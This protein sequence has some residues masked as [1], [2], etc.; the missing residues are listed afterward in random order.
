MIISLSTPIDLY[1][2]LMFVINKPTP[3]STT[4]SSLPKPIPGE[5]HPI[6]H[7]KPWKKGWLTCYDR[8]S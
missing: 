7:K 3:Y 4:A 2:L 6:R 8:P 1:M 5:E